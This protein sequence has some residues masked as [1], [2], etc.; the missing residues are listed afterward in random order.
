VDRNGLK[1]IRG[2]AVCLILIAAAFLF[3]GI[4]GSYAQQASSPPQAPQTPRDDVEVGARALLHTDLTL[5]PLLLRPQVGGAAGWRS[6]AER[7]RVG[8]PTEIETDFSVDV[9][10][11]LRAALP[12]RTNH[13]LRFGAR[14]DY[15]WFARREHLRKLD[16]IVPASY[17][18]TSER[19]AFSVANLFV[20]GSQDFLA[21]LT[22]EDEP[23]VPEYELDYR[24]E[25]R[26][27]VTTAAVDLDLTA[28]LVLGVSGRRRVIHYDQSDDE[29]QDTLAIQRNRDDLALGASLG[30]R[31]LPRTLVSATYDRARSVPE[32]AGN[33]REREE[34]RF[35]ARFSSILNRSFSTDLAVGYKRLFY[36]YRQEEDVEA[37]TGNGVVSMVLADRVAVDVSGGRNIL[38]SYW[39]DN[40][41]FDRYGGAAAVTLAVSRGIRLG[42]AGSFHTHEYPTAAQLDPQ[43]GDLVSTQRR[44]D[45]WGYLGTFDWMLGASHSIQARAGWSERSS[46]FE[47]YDREGL[48][49]G[50]GY[51]IIY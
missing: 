6:I 34:D 49:L 13:L 4:G 45:I 42:V 23:V 41:Y 31:L 17:G 35:G 30:F 44:D 28:R 51:A 20:D 18:Y 2:R 40:L 14:L 37:I 10:P 9:S 22:F 21:P 19:L 33:M 43:E 11:E 12:M 26:S 38:P 48:I 46:N 24:H 15:H 32:Y 3:G 47:Q 29:I 27:N 7:L 25:F 39:R 50:A 36:S 1:P 5:G 8:D 16:V